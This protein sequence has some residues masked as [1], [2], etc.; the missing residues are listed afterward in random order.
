MCHVSSRT[1]P[2]A[3]R[4]CPA[5]APALHPGAHRPKPAARAASAIASPRRVHHSLHGTGGTSAASLA[6]RSN[7]SS[8]TCVVPS[9]YGVLRV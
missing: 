2:P 3:A 4:V 7:G 1:L 9:G 8:T 6:I 5:K